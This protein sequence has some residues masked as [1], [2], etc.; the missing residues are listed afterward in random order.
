MLKK[1]S[2]DCSGTP[3]WH[4][5]SRV[6]FLP[7]VVVGSPGNTVYLRTFSSIEI[8]KIPFR[9]ILHPLPDGCEEIEVAFEF[10][11]EGVSVREGGDEF[12]ID[13]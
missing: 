10:H 12:R 3:L 8:P 5:S 4:P 1:I 7:R 9:S 13:G 6:Q 2:T 11:K